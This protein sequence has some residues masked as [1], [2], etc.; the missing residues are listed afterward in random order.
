MERHAGAALA[1]VALLLVKHFLFDFVLQTQF[2]LTNKRIYGHPGGLLHA[3]LHVLGTAPAFLIITPSAGLG[4][5]ILGAEFVAHYHID[6]IKEQILR[7][8]RWGYGDGRFWAIFGGDQ[9]AHGLGYLLIAW[10]LAVR[11]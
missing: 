7:R 11:A 2:Q 5:L 10:V 1:V 3:G 6:W 4:A 8:T 9:L